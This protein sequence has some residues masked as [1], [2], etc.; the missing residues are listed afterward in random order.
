MNISAIFAGFNDLNSS[1]HSTHTKPNR[2]ELSDEEKATVQRIIS[3]YDQQSF[4][5]SERNAMF[6]EI[7]DAGIT[8]TRSV[9]AIISASGFNLIGLGGSSPDTIMITAT[10]E[11]ST[12][13]ETLFQQY[14]NGK[15]NEAELRAEILSHNPTYW[16]FRHS[17]AQGNLISVVA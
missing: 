4:S 2:N 15:I 16:G 12:A 17:Y 14:R 11:D 6:Q 8:I 5:H 7:R 1:H 10:T 3:G 13:G 9:L